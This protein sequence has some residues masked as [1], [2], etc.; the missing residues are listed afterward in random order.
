M[1]DMKLR[2]FSQAGNPTI[3]QPMRLETDFSVLSY[4]ALRH[5]Y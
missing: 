3:S 1:R 5:V 4:T 2:L